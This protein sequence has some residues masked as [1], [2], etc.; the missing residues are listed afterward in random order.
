MAYGQ[1]SISGC[2]REATKKLLLYSEW[3]KV[4]YVCDECYED[5]HPSR[6]LVCQSCGIPLSHNKEKEHYYCKKCGAI[7]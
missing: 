4:F 1:C 2:T 5:A 6:K 7:A 3:D